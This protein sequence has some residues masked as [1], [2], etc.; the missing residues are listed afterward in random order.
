[1]MIVNIVSEHKSLFLGFSCRLQLQFFL[2]ELL[3]NLLDV[4]HHELVVLLVAQELYVILQLLE[5][6]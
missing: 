5:D 6:F 1:M 4:V 2:S 3:K